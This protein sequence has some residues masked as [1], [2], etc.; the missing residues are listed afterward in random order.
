MSFLSSTP[1]TPP[2]DMA[3]KKEAIMAQVRNELALANAQELMTKA[4][5]QCYSK[6]V[7]KP[8][9]SLSGSEQ[10]TSSAARTH[11]DWLVRG[12]PSNSSRL[13]PPKP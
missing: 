12:Q 2:V 13:T 8:G 6:C 4:N 1:S 9:D 11:Q 3:A 5:E 7:T 10:L